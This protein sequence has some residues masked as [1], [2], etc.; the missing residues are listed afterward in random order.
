MAWHSL[1]TEKWQHSRAYL[2]TYCVPGPELGTGETGQRR[3]PP[4]PSEL[5][6]GLGVE[7]TVAGTPRSLEPACCPGLVPREAGTAE[8]PL[9]QLLLV[10]SQVARFQPGARGERAGVRGRPMCSPEQGPPQ[11]RPR[12]LLCLGR[13]A[14]TSD[15][16]TWALGCGQNGHRPLPVGPSRT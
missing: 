9:I 4:H 5:R 7:E 1:G 6:W 12:G 11:P 16:P 3:R 15:T 2:S 14:G 8:A 10:P 13:P